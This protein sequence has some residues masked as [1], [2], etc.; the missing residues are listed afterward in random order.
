MS[1][2]TNFETTITLLS[3]LL[4]GMFVLSLQFGE[5][6]RENNIGFLVQLTASQG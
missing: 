6:L 1:N 2:S 3:I 4:A 5:K